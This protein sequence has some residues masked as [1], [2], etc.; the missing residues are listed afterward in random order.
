MRTDIGSWVTVTGTHNDLLYNEQGCG[1][2]DRL[3]KIITG[4]DSL[5]QRCG[6]AVVD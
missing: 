1:W 3:A 4:C 5:R 6:T 2:V